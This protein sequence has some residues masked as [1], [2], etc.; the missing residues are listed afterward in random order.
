[1]HHYKKVH[2]MQHLETNEGAQK[3]ILTLLFCIEVRTL[4]QL[5]QGSLILLF[6]PRQSF[7]KQGRGRRVDPLE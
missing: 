2:L 3:E 7:Q 6:K 4:Q 5:C 1:M